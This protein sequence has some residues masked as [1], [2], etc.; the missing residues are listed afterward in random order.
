MERLRGTIARVELQTTKHWASSNAC[1]CG[2]ARFVCFSWRRRGSSDGGR[3][4]A[5]PQ[6]RDAVIAHRLCDTYYQSVRM[7]SIAT[8]R[9]PACSD[10]PPLRLPI[11]SGAS[12]AWVWSS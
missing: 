11:P 10:R 6:Y 4:S 5:L 2:C 12:V 8:R 3:R 7:L 9:R 1:D